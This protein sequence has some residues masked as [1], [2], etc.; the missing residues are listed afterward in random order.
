MSRKQTETYDKVTSGF[1]LLY[2]Y[3]F[4]TDTVTIIQLPEGDQIVVNYY[5]YHPTSARALSLLKTPHLKLQESVTHSLLQA[6][7]THDKVRITC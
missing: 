2:K 4:H 3:I 7:T 1:E 5:P 6:T